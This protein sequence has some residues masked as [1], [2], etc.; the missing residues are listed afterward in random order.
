MSTVEKKLTTEK[1]KIKT[2]ITHNPTTSSHSSQNTALLGKSLQYLYT[3]KILVCVPPIFCAQSV[4][5]K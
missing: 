2:K 3:D 4:Q 1:N 5:G